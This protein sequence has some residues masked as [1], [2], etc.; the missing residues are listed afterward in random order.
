VYTRCI[1]YGGT[2]SLELDYSTLV[3]DHNNHQNLCRK[4]LI[5]IM[6]LAWNIVKTVI[7][8]HARFMKQKYRIL[9]VIK[10][11]HL[12]T[13]SRNVVRN[14]NHKHSLLVLTL[15]KA[16]RSSVLC[17]FVQMPF[18]TSYGQR[19]INVEI[20]PAIKNDIQHL[21]NKIWNPQKVQ[22]TPLPIFTQ[23][24]WIKTTDQE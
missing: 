19:E 8:R 14:R 9:T 15:Y 5:S 4:K 24:L 3:R 12:T 20:F 22:L 23:H 18:K 17:G 13:W 21:Q 7:A 2:G 11:H 6:N 10:N 16:P 1:I